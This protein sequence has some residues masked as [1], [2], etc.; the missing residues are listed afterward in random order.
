M[1]E[2]EKIPFEETRSFSKNFIKYVNSKKI[3]LK[4]IY[5][6]TNE[7]SFDNKKR[8][9]LK[10]SLIKQY[11]KIDCSNK[12][13]ANINQLNNENTFTVTTGHQLNIFT[14]PLYVIYKIIST[15]NLASKLKKKYP[16]KNFV[17]IYWMASEDHDYEEIKSFYLYGK[18]YTWDIKTSGAVGDIDPKRIKSLFQKIPEKISLFEKAYL[19]NSKLSNSVLYYM[20]ELF[21]KYGLIVLEPN[22]KSYKNLFLKIIQDDIVNNSIK[23]LK[24]KT[25]KK[26]GIHIRNINFFYLKK[27]LRERII[28][29]KNKYKI[30]NTSISFSEKEIIKEINSNSEFFSPNVIMR[31]LYQQSIIPNIAYVGGPSEIEYWLEFED[32]FKFYKVPFPIILPRNFVIIVNN[33]IKSKIKKLSIKLP[34]IFKNKNE[35]EKIILEN[36]SKNKFN[37]IDEKIN[38]GKEIKKIIDKSEKIDKSL[39]SKIL[40]LKKKTINEID[41]LEKRLIREERKKHQ[42]SFVELDK[43]LSKLFPNDTLQERKENFLNYYLSDKNFIDTLLKTLDPLKFYFNIISK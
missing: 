27:N 20:N 9:L 16:K 19:N 17:P 5:L 25:S 39:N 34:D 22:N 42:K 3:N 35:L 33:K 8:K 2:F 28:K 32:F 30:N 26:N 37:L 14:G 31:C 18:N 21:G 13:M 10:N 40:A 41:T 7:I 24:S 4:D 6:K 12:V 36:Q 29:E 43:I 23:N 15:I 1:I 38:V 11:E